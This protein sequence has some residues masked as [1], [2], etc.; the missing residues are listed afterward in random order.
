MPGRVVCVAAA[1]GGY[2]TERG[3]DPD[4]REAVP[5][6]P[7]PAISDDTQALEEADDQ[8]DGEQLSFNPWKTIACHTSEVAREAREIAK[9][10]GLPQDLQDII[11]LAAYW[12]DWGK[13]HPAFQGAMRGADRPARIDLAKGPKGAWL[14]PPRMYR[15]LD[16][17]EERPAFRHELAS[18]LGLFAVLQTYATQHPA[19]L[20]PWSEV[21]AKL[22]KPLVSGESL[23]ASSPLIQRVL[24]C[25]PEAFDLIV[26]LVPS[27]H[28][29]VRVALHAAPKDQEYRDRDG[30]GLPIRGIR[31]GD[32]LPS[33]VLVP[34]APALPEVS[35]TL[36]P[37]AIG[38]S[39]RTGISWRER[40][41]GLLERYGPAGL[42]FLEAILRAAD[43]RASRLKTNDPDLV[44]EANA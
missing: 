38:L 9:Q 25:S 3:F 2:R 31:E 27:H 36:S 23:P 10:L 28:G 15:Y 34:G 41:L 24:D 44:S 26:Y 42:A 33:V 1:C 4:W 7:S 19:L 12:H 16:D 5:P 37:A 22:G 35:L 14:R 20:G 11:E 8:Q 30:R 21:L 6:V 39:E 18:A 43:V 32:R 13:S 29:K 40:C 17:T